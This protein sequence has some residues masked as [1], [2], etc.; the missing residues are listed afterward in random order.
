L[1]ATTLVLCKTEKTRMGPKSKQAIAT[2]VGDD[3]IER[4]ATSISPNFGLSQL[5]IEMM[6]TLGTWTDKFE[7]KQSAKP[8]KPLLAFSTI[9]Q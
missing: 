2:H 4:E 9:F 7:S 6:H 8:A 1:T 5:L 3:S